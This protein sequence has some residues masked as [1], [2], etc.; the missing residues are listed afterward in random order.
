MAFA[1]LLSALLTLILMGLVARHFFGDP[2]PVAPPD[3]EGRKR[4]YKMGWEVRGL[5]AMVAGPYA[6]GMLFGYV[7]TEYALPLL[8]FAAAG[9][10]V[11]EMIAP[12]GLHLHR[13]QVDDR[14]LHV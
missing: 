11:A 14:D 1:T 7:R 10:L 13:Q 2:G 6:A 5:V 3:D 4:R 12:S 8:L 9:L